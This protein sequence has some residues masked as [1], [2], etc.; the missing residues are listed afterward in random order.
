MHRL[1]GEIDGLLEE[2]DRAEVS[3]AASLERRL[4]LLG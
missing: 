1:F 4:T 2:S 3:T